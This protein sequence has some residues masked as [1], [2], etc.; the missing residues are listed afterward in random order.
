MP[1]LEYASDSDAEAKSNDGA[2][3]V[4][5]S[6]EEEDKGSQPRLSEADQK[7]SATQ[8]HGVAE[9]TAPSAADTSASQTQL[10]EVDQRGSLTQPRGG[11][12]VSTQRSFSEIVDLYI[13]QASASGGGPPPSYKAEILEIYATAPPHGQEQIRTDMEKML[14]EQPEADESP[15]GAQPDLECQSQSDSLPGADTSMT[16]SKVVDLYIAQAAAGGDGPPPEYKAQILEIYENAPPDGQEQ[17]LADMRKLL[18]NDKEDPP[19][20]SKQLVQGSHV[21]DVD[22]SLP[23]SEVVDLYIAQAAA[24]GDGPP[25][26]Y[27][28]QILEIYENAPP[29]GQEQMVTDMR[30]LVNKQA[31]EQAQKAQDDGSHAEAL[32]RAAA[33]QEAEKRAQMIA[34]QKEAMI[35]RF[36]TTAPPPDKDNPMVFFEMAVEGESIG[37][38]EFELFADVVPKTAENFRCLC[39]GEKGR[40]QLTKA[41][42][43]FLGCVFHRIIPGFMC[44][45]GDFTEGDGTGGESI[46]GEK[47]DDENFKRKHR[48]GCLSM[49]NSG[50]NTNGSQFFI[51]TEATS[52]L[53][54][55][56]VVFGDV[57][58]G[59][60]VVQ[61]ME[62]LGSRS[63]RTLKKVSILDCGEV[64]AE[65]AQA[66]KRPRL[67]DFAPAPR[68]QPVEE[69]C[70]LPD[71]GGGGLFALLQERDAN[72]EAR[73]SAGATAPCLDDAEGE[74]EEVHVLHILK[75]HTGS[76]KPKNR[77]GK[78][79]TCSQ[80]EAQEYLERLAR[81]LH[82]ISNASDRRARFAELAKEESDCASSRKGGDYG[83]FTRGK[84]EQAFEDASFALRVGELSKVVSTASGEHIILRVP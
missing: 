71:G 78:L 44:Q 73:D 34:Q 3:P 42:L 6:T 82:G 40:S 10:L 54:G 41:R 59:Y 14:S 24:D 83:R 28:A 22:E 53:D 75:K 12:G 11:F 9:P 81:E 25:P 70:L 16:F 27:K 29:E 43:H 58:T 19:R 2:G 69:A 48:K 33:R 18:K 62:A 8:P 32:A 31:R 63:G 20:Q 66:L 79:V 52:H 38:I 76:R 21:S 74:P 84:R 1:L 55:K 57:K 56:H 30:D 51:C 39:T 47:F 36:S 15:G 37:R 4:S 23:F 45:G 72:E 7:S 77:G 61:K 46:Y 64:G 60:E 49:A 80:K 26:E 35:A 50:K 5:P 67:V 17:M 65:E 13:A 68:I